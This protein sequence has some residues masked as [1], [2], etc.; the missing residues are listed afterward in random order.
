M[1][2]WAQLLVKKIKWEWMQRQRERHLLLYIKFLC[3]NLPSIFF[4]VRLYRVVWYIVFVGRVNSGTVSCVR[5]SIKNFMWTPKVTDIIFTDSVRGLFFLS[6]PWQYSSSS[7]SSWI[8]L[9]IW[10]WTFSK[11]STQRSHCSILPFLRQRQHQ[12]MM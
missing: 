9:S 2:K 6:V 12:Q 10:K 8:D 4:L 1:H 11:S 7:W 3:K 5:P